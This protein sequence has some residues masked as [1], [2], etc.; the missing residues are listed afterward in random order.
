MYRIGRLTGVY[1]LITLERS[2]FCT[3][4]KCLEFLAQK[5]LQVFALFHFESEAILQVQAPGWGLYLEGRK[6]Q[7]KVILVI[8]I[9]DL[10]EGVLHYRL[11]GH[12]IGE[13]I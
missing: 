8:Q 10:T 12:I 4:Q 3:L 2:Y 11:G 6:D 1:S 13:V 9:G 5:V 7:R